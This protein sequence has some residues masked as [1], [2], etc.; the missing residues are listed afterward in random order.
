VPPLVLVVVLVLIL[1]CI[2]LPFPVSRRETTRRAID[3][4][5]TKIRIGKIDSGAHN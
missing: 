1:G 4:Q 5:A 2:R 3:Q